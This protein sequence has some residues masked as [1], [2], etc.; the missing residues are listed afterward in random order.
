MLI[1]EWLKLEKELSYGKYEVLG[2]GPKPTSST[3]EVGLCIC[4]CSAVRKRLDFFIIGHLSLRQI[5]W[6]NSILHFSSRH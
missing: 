1:S 3:K 4:S 2:K 6:K 5:V